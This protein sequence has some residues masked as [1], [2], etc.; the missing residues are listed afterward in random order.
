MVISILRGQS[1]RASIDG[2]VVTMDDRH[3]QARVRQLGLLARELKEHS[4]PYCEKVIVIFDDQERA[5]N[6]PSRVCSHLRLSGTPNVD[7][8]HRVCDNTD[9]RQAGAAVETGGR[10]VS[11][12][13]AGA[14]ASI[15]RESR[16]GVSVR[17][18]STAP[19]IRLGAADCTVAR[20]EGTCHAPMTER[21]LLLSSPLH[22]A[23]GGDGQSEDGVP[24]AHASC[25]TIALSRSA[26][27]GRGAGGSSPVS[28]DILQG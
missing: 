7:D 8:Q 25:P 2:I 10:P 15:I 11:H 12:T 6:L 26:L 16:P 23:R 28:G 5:G 27:D 13:V 3:P 9:V 22:H 24:L 18:G 1:H 19:S 17:R 4:F 14:L 20:T 21:S